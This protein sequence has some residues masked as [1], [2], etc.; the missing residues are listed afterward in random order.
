[1]SFIATG[2][3]QKASLIQY[4]PNREKQNLE[5]GWLELRIELTFERDQ[6]WYFF[7]KN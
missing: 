5:L 3:A 1:M 6:I 2:F 7:M 4:L